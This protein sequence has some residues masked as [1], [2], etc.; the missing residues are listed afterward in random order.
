MERIGEMVLGVKPDWQPGTV[1]C[2]N[3]YN[4]QGTPSSPEAQALEDGGYSTIQYYTVLYRPYMPEATSCCMLLTT[5]Y[6]LLITC[7]QSVQA[8]EAGGYFMLACR[9][10]VTQIYDVMMPYQHLSGFFQAEL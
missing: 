5:Y 4:A 2:D 6:L 10:F 1:N 7:S 9:P 8:L 3:H